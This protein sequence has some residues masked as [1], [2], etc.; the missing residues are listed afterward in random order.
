M[1]ISGCG[2]KVE[3]PRLL[4]ALQWLTYPDEKGRYMDGAL[5]P[6]LLVPV[7]GLTSL[8]HPPAYCSALKTE[9]AGSPKMQVKI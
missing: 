6:S 1:Y 4:P 5:S 2:G 9:V 7:L 8:Y 3:Y